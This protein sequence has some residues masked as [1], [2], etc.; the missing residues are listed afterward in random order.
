MQQSKT[1]LKTIAQELVAKHRRYPNGDMAA[2]A[3][4]LAC[5]MLELTD[6]GRPPEPDIVNT[7]VGVAEKMLMTSITVH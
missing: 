7:F 5:L 2:G 6:T 3:R 4:L 1:D